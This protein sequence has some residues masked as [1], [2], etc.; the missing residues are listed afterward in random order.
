MTVEVGFE[1]YHHKIFQKSRIIISTL[2]VNDNT[3]FS[4]NQ[5]LNH[6]ISCGIPTGETRKTIVLT[7]VRHKWCGNICILCIIRLIQLLESR[8][9]KNF[10]S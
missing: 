4:I 9:L 5:T 8:Y 2:I 1:N 7:V 6:N 3:I 10:D